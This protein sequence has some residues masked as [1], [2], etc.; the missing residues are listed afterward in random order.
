MEQ[1]KENDIKEF[2]SCRAIIEL[3]GVIS[4]FGILFCG[5]MSIL[6]NNTNWLYLLIIFVPLAILSIP[7]MNS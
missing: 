3:L 1:S 2:Q 4:Y 6:L 5:G 7:I